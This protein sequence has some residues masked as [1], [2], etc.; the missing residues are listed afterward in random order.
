[1]VVVVDVDDLAPESARLVAADQVVMDMRFVVVVVVAAAVAVVVV[2]P[3]SIGMVGDNIA[4]SVDAALLAV[5]QTSPDVV[6]PPNVHHCHLTM[7]NWHRF[8]DH[9][10]SVFDVVVRMRMWCWYV[11]WDVVPVV[12]SNV[13]TLDWPMNNAVHFWVP[14]SDSQSRKNHHCSNRRRR[15]RRDGDRLDPLAPISSSTNG[16]PLHTTVHDDPDQTVDFC[17]NQTPVLL[18]RVIRSCLVLC[19][20]SFDVVPHTVPRRVR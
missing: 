1:M 4:D 10:Y 20:D 3:G 6:D 9:I 16:S 18:Y 8:H 11:A 17:L 15:C 19:T 14:V 12:S 5:V 2:V 7:T 13:V